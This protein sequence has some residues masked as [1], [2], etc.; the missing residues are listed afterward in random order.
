MSFGKYC[1]PGYLG[2]F[3]PTWPDRL[4]APV[5]ASVKQFLDVMKNPANYPVLVH[6]FAGKHR[7]GAYCAIY[8][9]EFENWTNDEAIAEIKRAWAG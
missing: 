3:T 6:C 9:M 1:P 5:D 2:R 8:R 4:Q 7:T